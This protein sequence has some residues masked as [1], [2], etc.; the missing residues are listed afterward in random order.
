MLDIALAAVDCIVV[1]LYLPSTSR[2]ALFS[3]FTDQQELDEFSCSDALRQ[4]A[5]ECL[6][7]TFSRYWT[8]AS[9]NIALFK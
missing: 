1:C 9:L 3:P 8:H 7:G 2:F 6:S 4:A 5:D